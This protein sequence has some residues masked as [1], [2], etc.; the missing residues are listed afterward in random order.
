MTP[1]VVIVGSGHAG[2]QCAASLRQE[3]FDGRILLVGDDPLLPYQR[4]PLS[5]AYLQDRTT[6][7][8]L[9]FRSDPFYADQRIERIHARAVAIDRACGLL[10]LDDGR[11]LAW[12]HL[13][14]ATGSQHRKLEV[15]GA[16][17][18]GVHGLQQLADADALK[19]ALHDSRHAVVVG[20][21]F[22]GLEFAALA[23]STGLSVHVVE[24]GTRPLARAVGPATSEHVRAL[25]EQAGSCF[26]WGQGVSALLGKGGRVTAVTTTA[27]TTL[28]ADIVL[29][30][31]GAVPN[32]HLATSAGLSVDN[33]ICVNDGLQTEDPRIFAIG[34]VAA[35]PHPHGAG[36]LRL[37][38][39]Q[40]ASDQARTVAARI[41]GKAVDY[42]AVPWFWSE[43]GS[44]RLQIAGVRGAGDEEIALAQTDATSGTRTLTVL[45]FGGDRLNAVETVNRPADHMLA[46]RLLATGTR[47]TPAEARA[48]GFS[49]KAW[50]A[51]PA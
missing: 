19:A 12:D 9:A 10:A 40:N 35:F 24:L 18:Q 16:Q 2:F 3:A 1:T 21:G 49:L 7:E 4:P 36:R 33:G 47:L 41:A 32:V 6:A 11:R 37:E 28:P 23:R 26:L 22:I 5:K 50:A 48:P 42:K 15:P 29:V 38:S 43:Q 51:A 31:I 13:V 8:G 17:L 46:R 39:V 30:G 14:L 20:A 27:G 25:H 45:A 44:A 34:D